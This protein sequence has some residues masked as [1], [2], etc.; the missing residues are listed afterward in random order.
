LDKK[1]YYQYQSTFNT[2]SE[3]VH[4]ESSAYQDCLN[5]TE[6]SPRHDCLV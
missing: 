2:L 4:I 6:F 1:E 5:N 3:V